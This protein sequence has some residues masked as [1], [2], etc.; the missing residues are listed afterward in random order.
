MAWA[1]GGGL[2]YGQNKGSSASPDKKGL[3]NNNKMCMKVRSNDMHLTKKAMASI[4]NDQVGGAI[5]QF[6]LKNSK[7][8]Q[9]QIG[10]LASLLPLATTILGLLFIF[11]NSAQMLFKSVCS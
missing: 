6:V 9:G 3:P 11:V 2:D 1:C 5:G 4:V 8:N 7:F 10:G